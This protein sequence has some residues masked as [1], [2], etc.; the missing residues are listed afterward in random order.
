MPGTRAVTATPPDQ[1]RLTLIINVQSFGLT[2]QHWKDQLTGR[3]RSKWGK[4]YI[5]A[6][7]ALTIEN[8]RIATQDWRGAFRA[9]P[10]DIDECPGAMFIWER[11]EVE[12]DAM[13]VDRWSNRALGSAIRHALDAIITGSKAWYEVDFRFIG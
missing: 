3:N 8:R 6:D 10:V 13:P 7:K 1:G 2:G 9:Q 4:I 11:Q 12:A 5:H